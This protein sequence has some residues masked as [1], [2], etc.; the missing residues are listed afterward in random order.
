MKITDKDRLD[1]LET[2][3]VS[4]FYRIKTT[5]EYLHDGESSIGYLYDGEYRT[6]SGLTV[7]EAIDNAIKAMEGKE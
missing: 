2:H 6:S 1:F 5:I 7:R 3:V 4:Y